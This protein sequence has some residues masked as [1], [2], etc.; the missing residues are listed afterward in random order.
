MLSDQDLL[1]ALIKTFDNMGPFLEEF[2]K[3]HDDQMQCFILIL[4][5]F[6]KRSLNNRDELLSVKI[7]H[8][9]FVTIGECDVVHDFDTQRHAVSLLESLFNFDDWMMLLWPRRMGKNHTIVM[10]YVFLL[11]YW[12]AKDHIFY[13]SYSDL[14]RRIN[15]KSF[16]DGVEN[17][18]QKKYG[19]Q[20]KNSYCGNNYWWK[21]NGRKHNHISVN[22]NDRR[23]LSIALELLTASSKPKGQQVS[24]AVI[25]EF[26]KCS[27]FAMVDL[28]SGLQNGQLKILISSGDNH[29]RDSMQYIVSKF[30]VTGFKSVRTFECPVTPPC[31]DTCIHLGLKFGKRT[32]VHN[33]GELNASISKILTL[34]GVDASI[35]MKGTLGCT[36][37]SLLS[38]NEILNFSNN[39]VHLS[40]IN[41][42][43]GFSIA[44]DPG[45]ATSATAFVSIATTNKGNYAVSICLITLFLLQFAMLI[46]VVYRYYTYRHT[47]E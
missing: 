21:V 43:N 5:A 7:K 27:I 28:L 38:F 46:S 40:D 47:E 44:I 2:A 22:L 13:G 26:V 25:D 37:H 32:N 36:A 23:K 20:S 17:C 34:F 31:E 19:E 9:F 1:E 29:N 15:Y 18:L 6:L 16:F 24:C 8:Y 45:V 42:I 10:Y 14:T 12:P 30:P 33:L 39:V 3:F 41:G 11:L 4:Y 35:E